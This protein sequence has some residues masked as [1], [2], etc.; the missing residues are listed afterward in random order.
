MN[1]I[2]ANENTGR[3]AAAAFAST[4]QAEAA[5]RALFDAGFSAE[6]VG[7][8][9]STEEGHLLHEWLPQAQ[10]ASA[11][12]AGTSVAVG[13]LLGGLLGGVAAFAIPGVGLVLGAG[14]IATAA[15]GGGFGGGLIGPLRNLSAEEK[16]AAYLDE[17]LRAGDVVITLHDNDRSEQAQELLTRFGGKRTA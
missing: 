7:L 8:L 11:E 4:T 10:E 9:A 6:Q 3:L 5:L 2:L 1:D 13:G 15:A 12:A 17:R 14:L 16:V